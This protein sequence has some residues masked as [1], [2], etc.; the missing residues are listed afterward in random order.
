MK[1]VTQHTKIMEAAK[2]V[3]RGKIIVNDAYTKKTQKD[4]K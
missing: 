4:L 1:M 2:A 3:L